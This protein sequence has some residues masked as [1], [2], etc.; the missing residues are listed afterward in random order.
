MTFVN[1]LNESPKMYLNSLKITDI[2]K[3][4]NLLADVITNF[5]IR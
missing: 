4:G 2:S 1:S 5:N 3:Q